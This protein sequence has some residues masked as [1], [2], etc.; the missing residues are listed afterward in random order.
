MIQYILLHFSI[1]FNLDPFTL[2]GTFMADTPRDDVYLFLFP[3][4]IDDSGGNL[5]VHLPPESETY[6]WSL[7]PD[8]IEKLPQDALEELALPRVKFLA[9]ALGYQWSE[10]VYDSIANFHYGKGFDHTSQD[11][12][13]KF[14]YLLLMLTG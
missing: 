14:G 7:D 12:A 10:E 11:V 6:Y 8:G 4:T 1:S 13:I 2:Q 9:Q 3:A 5:A